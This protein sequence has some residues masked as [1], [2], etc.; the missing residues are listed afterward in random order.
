M[1][2]LTSLQDMIT[3]FEP[4]IVILVAGALTIVAI[5]IVVLR[6]RHTQRGGRSD[7]NSDAAILHEVRLRLERL[8]HLPQIDDLTKVDLP[9][10]DPHPEPE[11]VAPVETKPLPR[12]LTS[13]PLPTNA[14]DPIT[15]EPDKE[16]YRQWLKEWLLFAEQVDEQAFQ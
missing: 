3:G 4:R 9:L 5:L 12:R 2:K 7:L 10:A 11:H 6:R 14:E 8:P 13:P 16:A 1:K 15:G